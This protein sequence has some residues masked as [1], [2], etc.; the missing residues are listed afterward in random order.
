MVK[1]IS[2][3]TCKFNHGIR[4]EQPANS[5]LRNPIRGE[6][7]KQWWNKIPRKYTTSYYAKWE[8]R[9]ELKILPDDLF[10]I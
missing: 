8:P 3:N 2:C 4:C 6:V 7:V 5:C 1:E 9:E 10:E